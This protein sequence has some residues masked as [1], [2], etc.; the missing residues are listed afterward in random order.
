[1]EIRC[2]VNGLDSEQLENGSRTPCL[3]LAVLGVRTCKLCQHSVFRSS[4]CTM[5]DNLAKR[6]DV[7]VHRDGFALLLS[8]ATCNF[9][10]FVPSHVVHL[11][12]SPSGAASELGGFNRHSVLPGATELGI[13]ATRALAYKTLGQLVDIG[14]QD[15]SEVF[16]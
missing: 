12:T 10:C 7:D 8:S 15:I 1:M 9:A 3:S 4:C 14:V 11:S 6:Y 2:A 16:Q 13:L 5:M